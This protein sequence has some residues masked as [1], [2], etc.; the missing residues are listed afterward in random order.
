M[1]S[2]LEAS[3]VSFGDN[4]FSQSSLFEITEMETGVIKYT[5]ITLTILY[6]MAEKFV[7]LLSKNTF[8]AAEI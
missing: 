3:A 5:N 1:L 7:A 6:V 4:R 8:S 2:V